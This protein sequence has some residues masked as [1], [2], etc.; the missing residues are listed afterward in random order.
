MG[1][2][3]LE[4]TLPS[5]S[6]E[7][8]FFLSDF[9]DQM[10]N[11]III[12]LTLEIERQSKFRDG[13]I[14]LW[15]NSPGGYAHLLF[16]MVELIE[17]AKAQDVIV[18]TIVPNVA[19]SAGSM[20]AVTGTIGERYIG[21][22]AEHLIHYGSIMSFESTPKQVERFNRYKARYFKNN[23]SHYRKYC[24]IPNLDQ[25]MLDEG[26]FVP[27]KDAIKWKMADKYTDKLKLL[28]SP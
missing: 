24:E 3:T 28:S 12:P 10:E 4:N 7:N 1:P 26:W 16:H 6:E 18:R 21:K 19:F 13:R 2:L 11:D 22:T 14:D 27:A 5:K 23:I 20:L 8:S 25:E 15:I 17:R 9:D